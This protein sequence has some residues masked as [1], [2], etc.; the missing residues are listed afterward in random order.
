[1]TRRIRFTLVAA[2][3]LVVALL[4]H[5]LGQPATTISLEVG[6]GP[7]Q[8]SYE[9]TSQDI[10][11][12]YGFAGEGLWGN[13]YSVD[14]TDPATFSS[15]QLIVDAHAAT[16]GTSEFLAAVSFGPLFTAQSTTYAVN[17]R[18][19]D[20]GEG[21]LALDDR[22]TS[23]TVRFSAV[24]ADGI[25]FEATIECNRLLRAGPSVAELEQEEVAGSAPAGPL[26]LSLDGQSFE[27]LPSV[28]EAYC[29]EEMAEENDFQYNYY[30]SE[31]DGEITGVELYLYDTKR[32]GRDAEFSLSIYTQSDGYY[33]DTSEGY[34]DG[35]GTV[36]LEERGAQRIISV[37]ASTSDGVRLQISLECRAE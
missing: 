33:V 20:M 26:S 23:G 16:E 9:A 11:C 8:G 28:D 27:L 3:T 12:T 29:D 25:P 17:T 30:P 22:G 2:T 18:S 37:E 19:D 21:N 15:L 13:Q 24:T 1:M 14:A 6:A 35:A 10:T 4:A 7:N 34:E 31:G 5:A 32:L 36:T